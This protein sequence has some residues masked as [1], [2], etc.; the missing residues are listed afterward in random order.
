M[1]HSPWIQSLRSSTDTENSL[2][3]VKGDGRERVGTADIFVF[4]G[5]DSSDAISTGAV[6]R[7][8][9]PPGPLGEHHTLVQKPLSD[10]KQVLVAEG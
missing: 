2:M 8:Q 6:D 1:R 3:V 9:L 5:N 7:V 4:F 10:F